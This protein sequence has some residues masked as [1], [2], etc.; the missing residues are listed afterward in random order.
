MVREA[1]LSA[2][3]PRT[4]FSARLQRASLQVS[5]GALRRQLCSG[6]DCSLALWILAYIELVGLE[7]VCRAADRRLGVSS[8]D[9]ATVREWVLSGRQSCPRLRNSSSS[10]NCS[11]H[12]VFLRVQRNHSSSSSSNNK[13]ARLRRYSG[14]ARAL[15]VAAARSSRL[16]RGLG[17]FSSH[18]GL[19]A[20]AF[21][22][23][24]TLSSP[25]QG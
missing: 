6:Q 24:T 20:V 18:Q 9:L 5:S 2:S 3:R 22:R 1:A 13:V 14:E 25:G 19:H 21:F 8:S 17:S 4:R 12:A 15:W 23:V 16:L 10:Y 11:A 7:T